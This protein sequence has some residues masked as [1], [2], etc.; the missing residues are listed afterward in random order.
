MKKLLIIVGIL[1]AF[2][3]SSM[4]A[5]MNSEY[6]NV[7]ALNQV[8]DL[9]P[10]NITADAAEEITDEHGMNIIIESINWVLW[11]KVD[12]ITASGSAVDNG[13]I[14][15]TINPTYSKD[16]RVMNI[17][18]LADFAPGETVRLWGIKMRGYDRAFGSR[19]LW[20]DLNGDLVYETTDITAYKVSDT[21][22]LTDQTPPYPPSD[23][24]AQIADNLS[25][26][27]LSWQDPP[28]WDFTGT[29]L[30]RTR[31]RAG[32]TQ[33]IILFEKMLHTSFVDN[34]VR[35]GDTV[36]YD[37]YVH[38]KRNKG[39]GGSITLT[40]ETPSEEP[41]EEPVVTPPVEEPV[42]ITPPSTDETELSLLN[43]LYFY[44]K[45]R[46]A[47]KCLK[48]D[49]ACLWAKINVSY[50][51]ELLDLSD[52]SAS[53]SARDLYLMGI[54]IKFTEERYQTNCIEAEIPAKTCAALGRSIKR[55]RYF[56][57]KSEE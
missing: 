45:V 41:V 31:V 57:D 7:L 48:D 54:R 15:A 37:I 4:A 40:I 20:L 30:E 34:D 42:V 43:R 11:E 21:T 5:S 16:Y 36:T 49:S 1:F 52:V 33:K 29:T 23:F 35:E 14:A 27:T 9:A 8:R 51:Q 6:H 46:Y 50:T 2:P 18:V 3:G 56:L 17:P 10:I 22:T 24:T 19:F 38:D 53:L 55:A 12:E 44:Y 47:I 13:K 39:E 28:D 25:S 26:V 32:A